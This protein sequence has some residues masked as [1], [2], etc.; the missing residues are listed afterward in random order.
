MPRIKIS[1]EALELNKQIGQR[2]RK[3]RLYQK[4][5]QTKFAKLLNISYNQITLYE[6][7]KGDLCV[8]KLYQMAKILEIPTSELLPEVENIER[9]PDDIIELIT[10]IKKKKLDVKELIDEIKGK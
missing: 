7:G 3:W 1:P 9:L 2:I 8:S 6:K 4:I 5:S 10:L